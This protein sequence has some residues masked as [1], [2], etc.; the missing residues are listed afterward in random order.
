MIIKSHGNTLRL[1]EEEILYRHLQSLWYA[2]Y[3]AWITHDVGT[4]S[5]N[6]SWYH[7]GFST[8]KHR[9]IYIFSFTYEASGQPW[10]KIVIR[11]LLPLTLNS[12]WSCCYSPGATYP[13]YIEP[14]IYVIKNGNHSASMS[15]RLMVSWTC[16][17]LNTK[18][19]INFGTF[20]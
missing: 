13:K 11:M 18:L 15:M 6:Y 19:D 20:H 4:G 8:K 17:A 16:T 1:H 12:N 5:T 7:L 10:H 14:V 2:R 3:V 9:K